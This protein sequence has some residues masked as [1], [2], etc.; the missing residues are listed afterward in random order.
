MATT[1]K[2]V[3]GGGL[4]ISASPAKQN[5]YIFTVTGGYNIFRDIDEERSGTVTEHIGFFNDAYHK[6]G[7]ITPA[8]IGSFRIICLGT[9]VTEEIEYGS[10]NGVDY[11][12]SIRTSHKCILRINGKDYNVTNQSSDEEWYATSQS[13]GILI[14]NNETIQVTCILL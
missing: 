1:I 9:V 8:N 10:S 6:Y 4:T 5:G 13:N 12:N 3:V 14:H 2:G 11:Y 7:T